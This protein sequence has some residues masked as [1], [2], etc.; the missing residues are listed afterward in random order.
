MKLKFIAVPLFLFIII[1]GTNALISHTSIGEMKVNLDMK[2]TD[3]KNSDGIT[4]NKIKDKSAV[5]TIDNKE[6]EVNLT[7]PLSL[8][9]KKVWFIDGSSKLEISE[10]KNDKVTIE[11]TVK[12]KPD[13]LVSAIIASILSLISIFIQMKIST[14]NQRKL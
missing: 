3:E 11:M 5:F 10:I 8:P 9:S 14:M 4:L 2:L 6:V 7:D 13:L 12:S 1:V